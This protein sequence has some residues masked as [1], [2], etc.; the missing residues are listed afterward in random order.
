MSRKIESASFDEPSFKL[1]H[2]P[3]MANQ[4]MQRRAHLFKG[5]E[6][7]PIT[8][9][10]SVDA[11]KFLS[12]GAD[13]TVRAWS[14]ST[15]KELFRMAGFTAELSSLCL[16]EDLYLIT[17]GMEHFVCVHDFDVEATEVEDGYELEW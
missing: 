8:A 14:P 4:R 15:G 16:Q 10:A 3:R 1:E 9:L 13:G 11:S 5:H 17:D 6:E 2:W 12:A 7:M